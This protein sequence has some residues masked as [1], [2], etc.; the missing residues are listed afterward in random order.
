MCFG[1]MQGSNYSFHFLYFPACPG[2]ESC[3]YLLGRQIAAA[4]TENVHYRRHL[5]AAPNEMV[6]VPNEPASLIE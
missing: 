1:V 6:V 4:C 3:L 5:Y 2:G